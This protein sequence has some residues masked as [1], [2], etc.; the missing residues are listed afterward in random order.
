MSRNAAR[1]PQL[2]LSIVVPLFN[3]AGT[4]HELH[5]RL[6]EVAL[7]L[8]VD[9]EIIYV[10]DGSRDAT[11]SIVEALGEVDPRGPEAAA[12]FEADLADLIGLVEV[13]VRVG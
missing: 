5:R 1:A 6:G 10:D 11:W 7:L 3:E 8:G 4:L 12:E 9:T 2:D 13:A